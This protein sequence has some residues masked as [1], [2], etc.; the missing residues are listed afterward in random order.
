MV[1]NLF[2]VCI[3]LFVISCSKDVQEQVLT[4]PSGCDSAQMHYG[5][6]IKPIISSNCSYFGCHSPGGEGSFDY[7][8]Y[9]GIANR[10]RAGRMLDRLA[11]PVE[12]PQ[13]MPEH[14]E[15]DACQLYK[16]RLWIA[17]GYPNN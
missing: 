3:L 14:R 2:I 15:M 9:E 1:K 6:D 16:L 5:S 17:Q 8:T 13:H 10:I 11:L 12:N 7:T 4:P